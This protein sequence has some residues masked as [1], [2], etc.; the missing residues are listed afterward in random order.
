ML[1]KTFGVRCAFLWLLSSV[2]LAQVMPA[3]AG[4]CLQSSLEA[5]NTCVP[6]NT[7]CICTT[8]A[9]MG[10]IQGCVL[11]SCT[12]KEALSA[13]NITQTMCGQPVRDITHITPIVS[14]VS[15]G[16]AIIAVVVRCFPT[17]GAFAL[18]DIFA[19]AALVSALPMGILEFI[20]AADGFGKDIWNIPHE[21]IYRII[22]FTW[23]TEVF[24]FM[25]VA[26]T[27]ISFLYFCLRIFP[28]K[29]LRTTIFTLV[30]IS[31]AYGIAFTIACLFNCTPVSFIWENWDG[32]H[33]GKCINFHVFAW[34]HAAINIALDVTIIAVPIPELL[35]L[36]LS[37]KKKVY[38]IMMFSI[39]AFTT[40]ISIVRLQSLVQFS[41]STNPTYDNVPT[42]YWSVL[43]AFVGI[44][45]VC[46]PALR[47]F[48]AAIFPRCF[49]STQNNSKYEHYDTP[50]TPN[51]L[52]SGKI[53]GS[54]NSKASFGGKGITK[55][56]ET[57]I[58]SR[59]GEDDE[60]QLVEL[61]QGKKSGW[62]STASDGG[63]DR[64]RTGIQ[65]TQ[66]TFLQGA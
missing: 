5:Q 52:S 9:L 46:M 40:I 53:T 43:E 50:N 19:I 33:K 15:G 28:R 64:S 12:L 16:A 66:G 51:R 4:Q 11:S 8:Q 34:A 13:Q 56:L 48:L 29:E 45:C 26:F 23:L 7:T 32:E 63:S 49:G 22:R 57:T 38:I 36:S 42:A 65:T 39:G 44:F 1:L 58:E 27:K 10:A 30:A 25:A 59:I 14:G 60:I 62:T 21:N 17:G 31:T 35:K 54:K 3:C 41:S 55:T 37:M 6:T 20:M 18:D 2:T 24:Y 47:R 61:E